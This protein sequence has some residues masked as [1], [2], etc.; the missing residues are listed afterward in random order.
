MST[1]ARPNVAH[2]QYVVSW[3]PE[4]KEFVATVVEFPSLSWL[5]DD[6]SAALQGLEQLV[7]TVIDDLIDSGEPVPE[8]LVDAKYSGDST[9]ASNLHFI[10]ASRLKRDAIE[11]R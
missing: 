3:S 4:D 1:E 6:Q 8:P 11:C 10:A 7:E 5:A 9:C 2:Y